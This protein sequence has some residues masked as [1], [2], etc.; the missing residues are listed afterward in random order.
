MTVPIEVFIN[1]L[2]DLLVSLTDL[3][4]F[5][6]KPYRDS[7]GNWTIGYGHESDGPLTAPRG[8]VAPLTHTLTHRAA[9]KLLSE[10]I[11][12][13]VSGAVTNWS[14]YTDGAPWPDPRHSSGRIG[15]LVEQAFQLGTYRQSLFKKMWAAI[16]GEDWSQA[17][18][19]MRESQWCKQTPVRANRCA[20]MLETNIYRR[21]GACS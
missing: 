3:E 13:A 2:G 12:S 1:N 7:L 8:E 21:W 17:A 20:L 18:N 6:D 16:R 11:V 19:E 9:M 15:G 14:Q 10:D 5:R 4:G